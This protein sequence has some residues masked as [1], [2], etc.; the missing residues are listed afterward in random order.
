[1]SNDQVATDATLECSV[2]QTP[3]GLRFISDEIR[4][5]AEIVNM[6]VH[7]DPYRTPT[8]VLPLICPGAPSCLRVR[9]AQQGMSDWAHTRQVTFEESMNMV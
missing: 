3:T 2:S 7:A 9:P 4:S 8:H 6:A 5:D 1:M